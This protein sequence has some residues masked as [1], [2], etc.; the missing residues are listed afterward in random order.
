[1]ILPQ[2]SNLVLALMALSLLLLGAWASMFKAAGKWRYELF[3]FDFAFGLIVAVAICSFTLG[4]LGFDGFNFIDDLQHAGKRQWIFALLAGM[5]FNLG[6]ML[7]LAAV[8]VAGMTVAFPASIGIALILSTLLGVF[9]NQ[10]GNTTLVLLGCLL[11]LASVVVNAIA[12]RVVAVLRHEQ[13]ARAG[14]AKST[15]RPNPVKGIILMVVSGLLIG[16]FGGL[17]VKA[18]DG[19]IGL[20][21]YAAAAM[22]ALGV[23]ISSFV[24]GVF[25]MNLPV[26]GEPLEFTEYFKGRAKQH[27]FGFLGGMLWYLGM[28]AAMVCGSVPEALQPTAPSRFLLSQGYPIIAALLGIVAWRELRGGDMRL[29]ILAAL[30]LVLFACGLTMI[31]LAPLYVTKL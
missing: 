7:L 23:F 5:I 16:S 19:E 21:P 10:A 24:Y 1:M 2:T 18:R 31:G 6:N 9:G 11:I 20:G 13:L 26:E 27:I 3:Y 17:M 29:R 8:S 4:D 22:F 15:R 14:I 12:Y 30:M 28:L 25:L